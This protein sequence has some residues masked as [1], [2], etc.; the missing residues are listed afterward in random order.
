MRSPAACHLE[1]LLRLIFRLN[2]GVA[3]FVSASE[4]VQSTAKP[5]T[6][7]KVTRFLTVGLSKAKPDSATFLWG[8]VTP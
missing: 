5:L 2:E 1:T 6:G 3:V 8:D 7:R 4:R